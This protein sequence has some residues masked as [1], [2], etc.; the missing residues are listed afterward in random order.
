[1]FRRLNLG[2]KNI[3]TVL[4]LDFFEDGFNV[5]GGPARGTKVLCVR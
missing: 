2:Y 5:T 1:L 4:P 3:D